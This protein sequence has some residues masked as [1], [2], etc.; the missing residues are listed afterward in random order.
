ML[1]AGAILN[2]TCKHIATLCRNWKLDFGSLTS[3]EIMSV[4]PV[5]KCWFIFLTVDNLIAILNRLKNNLQKIVFRKLKQSLDEFCI[6]DFNVATLS[7][8]KL[9]RW[10]S[11]SFIHTW[12]ELVHLPMN[13]ASRYILSALHILVFRDL[14]TIQG[15]QSRVGFSGCE[16]LLTEAGS[17]KK[18]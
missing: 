14:L 2:L 9:C 4:F 11:E 10:V 6:F 3:L 13:L 16:C 12:M 17:K 5:A 18:D 8:S 15:L 1:N 7:L